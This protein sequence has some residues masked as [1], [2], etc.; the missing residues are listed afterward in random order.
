MN[1]FAPAVE[2]TPVTDVPYLMGGNLGIDT[3]SACP[4]T[5]DWIPYISNFKDLKTSKPGG[6][7][8]GMLLG[9]GGLGAGGCYLGGGIGRK[10]RTLDA[11]G[12]RLIKR[13][14]YHG[15]ACVMQLV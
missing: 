4:A 13:Y 10:S 8:A 1:E 11:P 5:A 6:L 15:T 9:V 3:A 7:D 2:G 12:G 14:L